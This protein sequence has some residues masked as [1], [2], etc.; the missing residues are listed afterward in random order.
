MDTPIKKYLKKYSA[1]EAAAVFSALS[2][3]PA[4]QSN[5][6]RLEKAVHY[7]LSYCKGKLRPDPKFI[8]KLFLL[9]EQQGI[10][11]ME[12][13]AENVFTSNLWLSDRSYQV[14][15]GLWEGG[16]YQTQL[17]LN[18]VDKMPKVGEFLTL[19]ETISQVLKASD[20]VLKR[21]RVP[22]NKVGGDTP[23]DSLKKGDTSNITNL[24]LSALVKIDNKDLLPTLQP[25][26]WAELYKQDF[27]NT[28]L[29][30]KPFINFNN[31]VYIILPSAITT[32]IRRLIFSFCKDNDVFTQFIDSLAGELEKK[33]FET[34]LLGKYDHAP[35][36]YREVPNVK[37]WSSSEVLLNFDEGYYFHFIF[38]MDKLDGFDEEWFSGCTSDDEQLYDYIDNRISQTKEGIIRKDKKAKGC[39]IVVPCSFGRGVMIKSDFKN[40]ESWISQV[41]P[42]DDL[43]V[44]SND[45]DCS[46]HK[47]W[48][49]LESEY[50]VKEMGAKL[51]NFNGFLNLYAY[52]KGENYNLIPHEQ[53]QEAGQSPESIFIAIPTNCQVGL[54]EQVLNDCDIKNAFH[55]EHGFIKVRRGFVNSLFIENDRY[56]LFCPVVVDRNTL[57]VLYQKG[58]ISLWIEM[59]IIEGVEFSLQFQIFDATVSWVPQLV[60]ALNAEKISISEIKVWKVN[61]SF[62]KNI[63]LK[64][65]ISIEK[66]TQ[67][68]SSLFKDNVLTSYYNEDL[69]NGL[70]LPINTAEKTIIFSFLKH[71]KAEENIIH[72]IFLDDFARHTHFFQA[73]GYREHL[74]IQIDRE[75]PIVVEETDDKNIKLG[76]GWKDNKPSKNNLIEGKEPCKKYLSGIVASTWEK[77]QKRL[78]NLDRKSLISKLLNNLELSEHQKNRWNRTYKANLSLHENKEDL[79]KVASEKTSQF[80]GSSLGSR[81]LIEMAVCETVLDGGKN[82]GIL[83]IQELLCLTMTMHI[84][85]GVSEAINCDVIEPRLVISSFGDILYDHGFY[86]TIVSPYHSSNQQSD[87]QHS[88]KNYITHFDENKPI[89]SVKDHFDDEFL[90]AWFTEFQFDIDEARRFIDFIEDYGLKLNKLVFEVPYSTLTK[91][92]PTSELEAYNKVLSVLTIY[93]RKNWIDIP[94]PFKKTDWQP[95]K[96]RRRFSN[97]F[98]PIVEINEQK[99]LFISPEHIRRGFFHLLKSSYQAHLDEDHFT[100]KKMRKWIGKA[101]S[102]AGL[103]FNTKVA[104]KLNSLGWNVREEIKITEILNKKLIDLGDIDVLA[105]NDNLNVVL[106]IECKDLEFAK[107]Q[108]EIARQLNEFKGVI[109][110]KGKNDR[111]YKHILR[112][113][114][115]ESDLDGVA[116]FIHSKNLIV[117]KPCVLF[118]RIAPMNFTNSSEFNKDINFLC[119]EEIEEFLQKLEINV[120]HSLVM[121]LTRD[122]V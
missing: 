88:A 115:L 5:L 31:Q 104:E 122:I 93:P 116:K 37:S 6:C 91:A 25:N 111:L 33:Q 74:D 119:F 102:K 60:K 110:N 117:L 1:V 51:F 108:G 44:L 68:E 52:A 75:E 98:K 39:S 2:L 99:D 32:S 34:R 84:L 24:I 55:K 38:L 28:N 14:P 121:D 82:A 71:V 76:M 53:F 56:D 64:K 58:A 48:R 94:K 87:F 97:A 57:Q 114:E 105:W 63:R 85:G 65:D 86:D 69:I 61:F 9:M 21:N 106:V 26:E 22:L 20:N 36:R 79:Y 90:D 4:Y 120:P 42:P 19:Y 50:K 73:N 49:I 10:A 113:R 43:D 47:I 80:N 67:S 27:G 101:R 70:N 103:A 18:V 23:I 30:E 11:S 107:T 78:K 35:I 46:P 77:I 16:I 59:E 15:L 40:D 92:F 12:D 66:V 62:P 3:K 29:E 17:F 7:C 89:A 81:L 95:W 96:F 112:I 83:D 13:P 54:R 41:I 72:N 118:S 45:K 100:S 109:N 8:N